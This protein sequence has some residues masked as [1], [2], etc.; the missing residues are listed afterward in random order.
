MFRERKT[1]RFHSIEYE[2]GSTKW[3]F[4]ERLGRDFT[5]DPEGDCR[6][7]E[8]TRRLAAAEREKKGLRELLVGPVPEMT[9]VDWISA[10]LHDTKQKYQIEDDEDPEATAE[11]FREV[12]QFVREA[13]AALA[14]QKPE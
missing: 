9:R 3:L 5:T 10:L 7:R 11:C 12:D 6:E 2:C 4:G 14:Q 13:N 8:L 1:S